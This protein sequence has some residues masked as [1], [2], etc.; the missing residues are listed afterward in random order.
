MNYTEDSTRPLLIN[1]IRIA[2]LIVSLFG[3]VP[4][5][6][7]PTF[8]APS[9]VLVSSPA[10]TPTTEPVPSATS[11]LPSPPVAP[12]SSPPPAPPVATPTN[13]PILSSLALPHAWTQL[14]FAGQ[15]VHTLT[16][17]PTQEQVI[18]AGL[19]PDLQ[20]STDG[21]YSWQSL[22]QE[23]P[24]PP[25]AESGAWQVTVNPARPAELY[26]CFPGQPP[27]LFQDCPTVL[28]RSDDG[29]EH[30]TPLTLPKLPWPWGA[31]GG[32][33]GEL[34]PQALSLHPHPRTGDLYVWEY[35]QTD[36]RS[37]GVEALLKSV[38]QG[39]SWQVLPMPPNYGTTPN[40]RFFGF[41]A[42]GDKIILYGMTQDVYYLDSGMNPVYLYRSEDGTAPWEQ[43]A[44]PD[45][46]R[47][48]APLPGTAGLYA[49]VAS[50]ADWQNG[51]LEL[52]RVADRE[53][54]R[55]GRLPPLGHSFPEG[56]L[57]VDPGD[58]NVL[59]WT[60]CPRESLHEPPIE[61]IHLSEDGGRTWL[62]LALPRPLIV[63]DLAVRHSASDDYAVI[64]LASDDGLWAFR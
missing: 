7:S 55:I 10:L 37:G 54:E 46:P 62:P 14:A 63:N 38:D 27:W 9:A 25:C 39:Q 21:G 45:S 50:Y 8:V 29:G 17:H 49:A 11:L 60:D 22:T 4:T 35:L 36:P 40:H 5:Q 23:L 44:L 34:A 15:A 16:L 1:L 18:C 61:A 13:T 26:A 42:S 32:G 59:V 24:R 53:G 41:Y 57:R 48:Y 47:A 43:I 64:Y 58:A 51:D 33:P 28:A 19:G 3:C 12:T 30:W 2:L 20:R 52:Y 31:M 6:P 56:I